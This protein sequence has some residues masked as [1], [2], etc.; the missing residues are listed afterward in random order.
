MT[1]TPIANPATEDAT[2]FSISQASVFDISVVNISGPVT[3][4]V[5]GGPDVRLWHYTDGAWVDVT[6]SQTATQTCGVT[7]SFS[8]FATASPK[9]APTP[10]PTPDNTGVVVG[11]SAKLVVPGF[12]LD[13]AKLTP[14]MKRAIKKF[15]GNNPTLTTVACKGFTSLPFSARDTSIGTDRGKAVCNFIKKLNPDLSV[16]VLK[17]GHNNKAGSETG[18]VRIAMR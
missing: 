6:T 17:G 12:A 9:T 16:K 3:I 14:K 11:A 8:P 18:R 5:D 1:V 2:P 4:C 10:T 7:S 13:S 15:V